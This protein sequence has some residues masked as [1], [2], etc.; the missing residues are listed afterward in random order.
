M[1]SLPRLLA[2]C[3]ALA[4]CA[5]GVRL[6]RLY[7][8]NWQCC[9]V[10]NPRRAVLSVEEALGATPYKS[11]R[12][13]DKWVAENIF[14]GVANGFFIDVGSADGVALS[15]TYAL[16]RKGWTGICVDPFP[17]NMQGRTCQVFRAVVDREGGKHVTFAMAGDLGG[18]RDYLSS[19]KDEVQREHVTSVDLVTTTI[20][21]ILDKAKAPRFIHFMSLDIEGAEL[22]ALQGFPFDRYQLGALVVEH[23]FEE[24]KRAAIES[25]MTSHGYKRVHSW[26]ADDFYVRAA[27]SPRGVGD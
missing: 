15:N 6:G 2:V 13:Q 26:Y 16:E 10:P 1:K 14:R 27:S 24:E 18:I 5:F 25:L 17:R 11:D 9:R 19:T 8:R 20:G 3:A 21:D 22:A 4:A 23:N 7:E 12:G